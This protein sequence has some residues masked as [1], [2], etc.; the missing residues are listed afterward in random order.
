MPK[1]YLIFLFLFLCLNLSATIINVPADQ[2]T[3]QAGID[4]AAA[5]TDVFRYA[6]IDFELFV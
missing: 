4:I 2:P 3:I 5:E 6:K 1:R